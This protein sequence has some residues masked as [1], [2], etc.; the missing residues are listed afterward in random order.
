[1]LAFALIVGVLVLHRLTG[2]RGRA[3]ARWVLGASLAMFLAYPGVKFVSE[4][5]IGR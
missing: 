1:L 2:L 5:L 3:A 4:V